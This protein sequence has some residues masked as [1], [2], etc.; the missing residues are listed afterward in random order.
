MKLDAE[1]EAAGVWDG[2]PMCSGWGLGAGRGNSGWKGGFE[3]AM[4]LWTDDGGMV[5]VAMAS[6]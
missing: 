4:E 6:V 1:A 2:S 3:V 5:V